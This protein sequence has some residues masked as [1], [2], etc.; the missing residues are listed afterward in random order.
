MFFAL[1]GGVM[2]ADTESGV[3]VALTGAGPCVFRL[4]EFEA[5]LADDF[6]PSALDGLTIDPSGFNEDL[7]ATSEYRAH[8]AGVMS[9]RVVAVAGG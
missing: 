8:L 7:H 3:R 6:S 9:R 4:S 5:A 2:V 1:H